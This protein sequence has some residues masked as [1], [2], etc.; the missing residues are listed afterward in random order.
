MV[1]VA[2]KPAGTDMSQESWEFFESESWNNHEKEVT[3]KLVASRS[4]E[5]SRNSNAGSKKWHIIFVSPAA[6]HMEKVQSIVRQVYG[7]SPTDD[8]DDFNENNAF[9]SIFINVALQA[10]VHLGR[11]HMENFTIYQESTPEVCETVIP[12]D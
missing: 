11:D 8:L 10:A 12:S 7:R 5:N 6:P 9:W 1:E 3:G 4:S 2:V